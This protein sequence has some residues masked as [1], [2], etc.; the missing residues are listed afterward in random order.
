MTNRLLSSGALAFPSRPVAEDIADFHS[1]GIPAIG[2]AEYRM[3]EHDWD[4]EVASLRSSPVPVAY[5]VISS[6]FTLDDPTRWPAERD[7]VVRVLTVA[8]DC[9][10]TVVYGTTG[11]AGTL[12]W[13]QATDALARAVAPCLDAA[14]QLGVALCFET[15]SQ[16]RQDIG[17]VYTLRDQLVVADRT[18][19]SLCADLLWC[20]RE[21]ALMESLAA[22]GPR[23][24]IVQLSDFV[25]GTVSMPGRAVPGDGC[26]P[27]AD[28]VA[29]LVQLG[30][31]GIFDVELLGPRI[32]E[33]GPLAATT[34][35][36]NAI[37]DLLAHTG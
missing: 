2:V 19:M 10:A 26:V 24:K 13:E 20:W 27:L 29:G 5:L 18:G 11:P 33:E 32:D 23:L 25:L 28:I 14:A 16:M 12:T 4:A 22:A 15:T 36:V 8:R 6:M 21:P 1:A 35:G 17:Y 3:V 7:R 30:F 31:D 34:R 9:G 37:A